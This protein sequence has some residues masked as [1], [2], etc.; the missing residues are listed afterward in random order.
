V[1]GLYNPDN[2]Y[3][4]KIQPQSTGLDIQ[5]EH[6]RLYQG[7]K[8]L[9]IPVDVIDIRHKIDSYSVI[10]LP[11]PMLL[12]AP[13]IE[14]LKQ[15][16]HNGGTVISSFRAGIKDYDNTVYFNQANP[17][18]KLANIKSY[19]IESLGNARHEEIIGAEGKFS[20]SVWR[21]MLE[22]VDST[23]AQGL[24]RYTDE[25]ADYFAITESQIGS[26][27]LIHVST[28][29]AEDEF[30]RKL[31]QKVANQHQIK[32]YETPFGVELIYR[33][34]KRFILNHNTQSVVF[35]NYTLKPYDVLIESI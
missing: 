23:Q 9:N 10:L 2:I 21:D 8:R 5:H 29:V 24:Y 3:A 11:A 7:F 26:G 16:M 30:W 1:A 34:N 14:K 4:W 27:K 13:Q 15:F 20:A 25:F 28:A 19:Y 35:E 33:G 31:A 22:L 18:L 17:W 32:Y 6:F 12:T